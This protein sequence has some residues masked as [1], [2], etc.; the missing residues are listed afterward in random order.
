MNSEPGASIEELKNSLRREMR[1]ARSGM[2]EKTRA[3]AETALCQNI[4]E[5]LDECDYRCVAVYLS[6]TPEA[7]VDEAIRVLISCGV[8]ICAPRE[9]D[10]NFVALQSLQDIETNARGVREPLGEVVAPEKVDAIL[11]PGLAFDVAG[12][13]LGQGGG[14]YDRALQKMPRALKIGV[15]FQTQIVQSVPQDLHDARMDFVVTEAHTVRVD[16]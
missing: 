2:D 16:L 15:C 10:G 1:A 9:R 13:R 14:W 11:V 8:P 5:L 12:A 7:S 6:K 4:V 3:V